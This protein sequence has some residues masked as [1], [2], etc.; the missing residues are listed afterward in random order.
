MFIDNLITVKGVVQVFPSNRKRI[1]QKKKP[2][3][4]QTIIVKVN[5]DIGG[6]YRSFLY[7]EKG[8]L[9]EPPP[10][11]CHVTL[12]NGSIE[13]DIEK[14]YSFLKK[15]NNTK[16]DLVLNVNPYHHWKFVALPVMGEEI[17]SIRRKLNLPCHE[18]FH[19]TIGKIHPYMEREGLLMKQFSPLFI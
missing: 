6:L 16:I 13:L 15:L 8:L 10:F 7:K 5:D 9:L 18:N 17:N 14:H 3:E 1:K 11:G 2:F 12:N 4:E 19:V